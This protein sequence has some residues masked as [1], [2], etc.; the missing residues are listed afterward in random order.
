MEAIYTPPIALAFLV[1]AA[2][3]I[4]AL[5]GLSNQETA[6]RGNLFGIVGMA[7]AIVATLFIPGFKIHPLWWSRSP[8]AAPSA[9]SWRSGSA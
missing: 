1:A 6:K 3:F 8:A 4:L 2:L 7:I 5:R 9:R